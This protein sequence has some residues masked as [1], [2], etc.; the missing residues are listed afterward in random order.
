MTQTVTVPQSME[1]LQSAKV[2]DLRGLVAVI[3]SEDTDALPSITPK[4]L[5][6]EL[7]EVLAEYMGFNAEEE[8]ES[9]VQNEIIEAVQQQ[10]EQDVMELDFG[11]DVPSLEATTPTEDDF[12]ELENM[13]APQPEAVVVEGEVG[14]L[15]VSTGNT[16]VDAVLA[17]LGL[18]GIEGMTEQQWLESDEAVAQTEAENAHMA[19]I[20]EDFIQEKPKKKGS[21]LKLS[22]EARKRIPIRQYGNLI[23][24]MFGDILEPLEEKDKNGYSYE[25][26]KL[27]RFNSKA[28]EIFR[29]TK[30]HMHLVYTNAGSTYLIVYKKPDGTLEPVLEVT[31]KGRGHLQSKQLANVLQLAYNEKHDQEVISGELYGQLISQI[32]LLPI[33]EKPEEPPAETTQAEEPQATETTTEQESQEA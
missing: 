25:V 31:N 22:F 3:K 6:A 10:D 7:V 32:E 8:I 11:G 21:T 29:K 30:G 20:I 24:G 2:K 5:K 23:L 16:E 28:H 1:E 18:D 13:G 33:N 19:Q 4:S 17:E 27:E 12:S 15:A 26:V 14:Q 9:A